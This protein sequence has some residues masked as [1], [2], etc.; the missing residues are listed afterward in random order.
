MIPKRFRIILLA[1]LLYLVCSRFARETFYEALAMT[2]SLVLE[3]VQI[4]PPVMVISALIAVWVPSETIRRGLGT[5]SGVRG[6][7]LSLLIGSLSAGPIY[8]AFPAAVTLLKK[9]ASVGNIVIILSSWA[10]IKL[11]MFFVE[12]SFLG[13]KFASA[14]MVLTLPAIIIM[15]AIM[16]RVVRPDQLCSLDGTADGMLRSP[17]D[18]V[19]LP[20]LDCGGCGYRSCEDL[21][22]AIDEGSVTIDSCVMIKHS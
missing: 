7:I 9:G 1:C 13:L 2:G 4:L 11:P 12:S 15:G 14:R 18:P 3:M 19:T 22:R 8:A 21:A 5:G 16:E 10:V 17:G 20:M 6:T